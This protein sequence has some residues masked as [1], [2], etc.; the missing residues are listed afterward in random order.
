MNLH[1]SA[2]RPH[3]SF[4]QTAGNLPRV[5]SK[6]GPRKP[7]TPTSWL[8]REMLLGSALQL[9]GWKTTPETFSALEKLSL[10]SGSEA[11]IET[12]SQSVVR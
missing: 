4:D 9:D 6:L 8:S 7:S 2:S 11:N 3:I 10:H 5:F 12:S 1:N